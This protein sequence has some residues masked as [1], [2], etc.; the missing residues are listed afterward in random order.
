MSRSKCHHYV[1]RWLLRKFCHTG[2]TLHYYDARSVSKG[3][4]DRNIKTAFRSFHT[5]SIRF[6]DGCVSDDLET[7]LYGPLDNQAAEFVSEIEQILARGE[8]PEFFNVR[9]F[10]AQFLYNMFKRS[11]EFIE[12]MEMEKSIRQQIPV[13]LEKI[14]LEQGPFPPE[15]V[16]ELLRE[17]AMVEHVDWIRVGALGQQSKDVINRLATFAPTIA[18]AP[19]GRQFIIAGCPVAGLSQLTKGREFWVPINPHTALGFHE[20]RWY[21]QG[22]LELSVEQVRHLNVAWR[23]Q[24]RSFGGADRRLVESL[25]TPT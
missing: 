20:D 1:P 17:K 19:K 8:I 18:V 15:D 11:A 22:I 7:R 4:H 25:I 9:F 14:N 10:A 13:T 6:R 5:N 2:Q 3:V 12:S 24:S 16:E 23:K 21:H